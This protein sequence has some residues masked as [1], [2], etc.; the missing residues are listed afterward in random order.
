MLAD[1]LSKEMEIDLNRKRIQ[2]L[3]RIMGVEAI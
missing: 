1:V 3:T 2:R